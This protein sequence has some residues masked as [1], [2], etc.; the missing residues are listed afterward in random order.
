MNHRLYGPLFR[1]VRWLARR[2]FPKF[3]IKIPA[4]MQGPVVYVSHHQNMF[5]P[6][7]IMLWFPI[8]VRTWIYQ[9]FFNRKACYD[10]YMGYT[11]T[12]RFGLPKP[13]AMLAAF[14]VSRLVPA[15]F[16]SMRG[17]PVYRGSK[18][19]IDTFRTSVEAL[20]QG[21]SI[22]IFPDIHYSDA[23]ADTKELY[24][25]FLHLEKYYYN[26]NRGHIPFVPL[27]ASKNGR[28]I[29]AGEPVMFQ[30]GE[31]FVTGRDRVM[32]QLQAGLNELARQSGDL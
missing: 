22:L 1:A 16:H 32:R 26:M 6:V 5:G 8:E 12:K 25:G 29:T 15:F 28:V 31:D 2:V 18:Q 24:E 30:D 7:R 20:K 17:I 4:A 13:I 11:F 9:V 27:Y 19:I 3:E 10:Q 23:S 14:P 21:H